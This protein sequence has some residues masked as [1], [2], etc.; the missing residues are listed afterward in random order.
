MFQTSKSQTPVPFKPLEE[1]PFTWVSTSTNLSELIDKLRRVERVAI[2]LECLGYRTYPGFVG[3]MQMRSREED[4]IM[5]SFE[6][7]DDLE[8]LSKFR[9]P[10]YCRSRSY[11]D[12]S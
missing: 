6:L 11:S 12:S 7:R 5:D 8:D 10:K 3:L 4:W 1:T 9:Q 2:D